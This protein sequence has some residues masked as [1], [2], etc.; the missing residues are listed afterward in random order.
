MEELINFKNVAF[1]YDKNIIF[2]DLNI[3]I[4]K[5]DFIGI[6]GPNG[7]GKSTFL[8]L[9]LKEL[10]PTKGEVEYCDQI[11]IGYVEQIGLESD[12]TF[13]AS[14]KEIVMLGLYQEIGLFKPFRK[15][16]QQKVMKTLDLMGIGNL[17]N[18]Q[19]SGLSGGQQQRVMIAK[20]LV[21]NPQLLILDEATSSID[22]QSEAEFMKIICKLNHENHTTIILVS[23]HFDEMGYLNR[24]F[25]I[26]EGGLA[27]IQKE[28]KIC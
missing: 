19:L 27:E 1:N 16:H 7:S 10:K 21:S 28:H 26:G 23:H 8:K 22:N 3:K 13:P 6:I 24:L 2:D 18:K 5:G 17:A 25:E 4:Y 11:N 12:F 15:S 14:V 9:I 20:A